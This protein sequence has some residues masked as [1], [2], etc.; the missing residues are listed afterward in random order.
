MNKD[1]SDNIRQRLES[2][3]I[4]EPD[5]LWQGIEA[6]L[7]MTPTAASRRNA[8]LLWLRWGVAAA[9]VIAIALATCLWL[10]DGIGDSAMPV[11]IDPVAHNNTTQQTPQ[12]PVL[13][14][15]P[16]TDADKVARLAMNMMRAA[17]NEQHQQQEDAQLASTP[18]TA[19]TEQTGHDDATNQKQ[20]TG[21]N[22]GNAG[23]KTLVKQT[24]TH[25]SENLHLALN[26]SGKRM[27][28]LQLGA[29]ASG[30]QTNSTAPGSELAYADFATNGLTG[31]RQE[32]K[33]HHKMPI[34][35]GLKVKYHFNTRLFVETGLTYSYL[36]SDYSSPTMRV[37]QN[38]HYVGVPLAAGVVI[39]QNK[40]LRTYALLGGEC[41]RLVS[42]GSNYTYNLS[43]PVTEHEKLK[44]NRLLW[45]VNVGV[46]VEVKLLPRL[47]LYAEPGLV[48]HFSEKCSIDNIYKDKPTGF[49][50]KMGVR[51]DM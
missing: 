33:L 1:W 19:Q 24:Q 22:D 43:N 16:Q 4:D 32:V 40:W 3:S 51:F 23:S 9:A 27:H 48:H 50:L 28:R 39:W 35:V 18:A 12:Q 25:D 41:K 2:H 44:D 36:R 6:R 42:G 37:E 49:D 5:G 7:P 38:L 30:M 11:T 17:A 31:Y 46:G 20:Q 47:S 15:L 21:G 14:G 10:I 13:A 26:N 8:A 45:D 29:Y 34:N